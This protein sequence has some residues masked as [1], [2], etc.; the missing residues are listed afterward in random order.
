MRLSSDISPLLSL[1]LEQPP[2]PPSTD[3]SPAATAV[4]NMVGN[5]LSTRIGIHV[6]DIIA[7]H[8]HRLP[9]GNLENDDWRYLPDADHRATGMWA[10][11]QLPVIRPAAR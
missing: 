4:T 8:L 7:D 2:S 5:H 6:P 1:D 10:H 9:M 3:R 11:G